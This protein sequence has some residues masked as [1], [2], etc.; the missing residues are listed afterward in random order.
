MAC[1]IK[2]SQE[3]I[4]L[5]VLTQ[6]GQPSLLFNAMASN[7]ILTK[8]QSLES[9]KNTFSSKFKAT[10]NSELI[11]QNGEPRLYYKSNTGQLFERYKEALDNTQTGD[12]K[13]GIINSDDVS[14]DPN[15][16]S[17]VVIT[18]GIQL[19]SEE[20]FT[21]MFTLNANSNPDTLEGFINNQIRLGYLN[22]KK[23]S[24]KLQGAGESLE[25]SIVNS[26]FVQ[27]S[28]NKQFGKENVT[29]YS[30]GT[31][32]II[33]TSQNTINY[34]GGEITKTKFIQDLKE[35][36]Q[37][38]LENK[39]GKA[40]V[41]GNAYDI[42]R[43]KN[44]LFKDGKKA[45]ET[46]NTFTEN[47]LSKSLKTFL[48]KLGVNITSIE[49]YSQRYADKNGVPVTA[50]ALADIA[51]KVVAFSEGE[52]GLTELTEET[53]HFA[54]EA[55]QDEET[56]QRMLENVH[57]TNEWK[58]DSQRYLE[59]YS[60]KYSGEQLDNIL[61]REVLGKV[62]A[63]K[64]TEQFQETQNTPVE[65]GFTNLLAD[66]WYSLIN[67][68]RSFITLSIRTELDNFTDTI[69]NNILNDQFDDIFDGSTLNKSQFVLYSLNDKRV[70][71]RLQSYYN[72]LQKINTQLK[73]SRVGNIDAPLNSV[74]GLLENTEEL[75][76][77]ESWIVVQQLNAGLYAPLNKTVRIVELAIKQFQ[78]GD[79]NQN[80]LYLD[81]ETIASIASLSD[82]KPALQDIITIVEND[83]LKEAPGVDKKSVL[84]DLKSKVEQINKLEGDERLLNSEGA[85][86]V[87]EAII[88]KSNLN[89][90]DAE[91]VRTKVTQETKDI[92]FFTK[93]FGQLRLANNVFLNLLGK[94]FSDNRTAANIETQQDIS[95]F[96]NYIEDNNFNLNKFR[97]IVE[98]DSSG[99]PTGRLISPVKLGEFYQDL[100]NKKVDLIRQSLN[101]D[102]TL[103]N[104]DVLKRIDQLN[105]EQ[106]GLYDKELSKWINENTERQ[107]QDSYYEQREL[108]TQWMSQ[109]TKA[110]I[111]SLSSRRYAITNKYAKGEIISDV[112]RIELEAIARERKFAKANTN[113]DGTTKNPDSIEGVISQDLIRADKEF[114][115][116][117]K[118]KVYTLQTEFVDNLKTLE[119]EQGNKKSLKW[120]YANGG[121][122][123]NSDFYD[124]LG[125]KNED[126]EK[127]KEPKVV[128][129]LRDVAGEE[130]INEDDA[131]KIEELA[132]TLEEALNE[133]SDILRKYQKAGNPSEVDASSMSEIAKD[134]IKELDI[135]IQKSFIEA[136]SKL[137]QNGITEIESPQVEIENTVNESYFA[138]LLDSGVKQSEIGTNV[139]GE[140]IYNNVSNDDRVAITKF[141][142]KVEDIQD[143]LTL[144][145]EPKDRR[146]FTTYFN[147]NSELSDDEFYDEVQDLLNSPE[148]KNT[149]KIQVAYGRTKLYSY[150]KRFAPKGYSEF[151][152]ALNNGQVTPSRLLTDRIALQEEFPVTQFIEITPSYIW[153]ENT[154]ENERNPNYN[155]N[156]EGGV[157]QPKLSRY[158]NSDYTERFSP[159]EEGQ[160]TKN[161][162]DFQMLQLFYAANRKINS[163][164]GVTTD[165][166]KL[167]QISKGRV[168]KIAEA[169]RVGVGETIKRSFKDT[170]LNRID[171]LDY[172]LTAENDSSHVIPM[173]YVY[174]LEETGDVSLSLGHTFAEMLH[175]SNLY[176]QK[177]KSLSSVMALLQQIEEQKF[178]NGKTGDNSNALAM[179]K[180]F[181]D[182]NVFGVTQSKKLEIDVFGYKVDVSRLALIVHRF[183]QYSS[184]AFSVPVSL[185]NFLTGSVNRNFIEARLGQFIQAD[186]NLYAEKEFDLK[187][188]PN[189]VRETGK[190]NRTSKT[191]KILEAAGVIDFRNRLQNSG[192]GRVAVAFNNLGYEGFLITDQIIKSKVFIATFDDIR[193][194]DGVGFMNYNQYKLRP[195]NNGLSK[196][197]INNK[198]KA[199][200]E[201]SLWN[202]LEN[203]GTEPLRIKQSVIDLYGEDT[204]NQVYNNALQKAAQT[205][206]IIDGQTTP[207]EKSLASRDYLLR[208]TTGMRSFLFLGLQSKFQGK[209]TLLQAGENVEGYYITGGRFVNNIVKKMISEKGITNLISA[210]KTEWGSLDDVGKTNMKRALA[211]Y[212]LYLTLIG[213]ATLLM[214]GADDDDSYLELLASYT[215]LRTTSET[216]GQ[217][218]TGVTSNVMDALDKP[219]IAMEFIKQ[220]SKGNFFDTVESGKYEGMNRL[221]SLVL[222]NTVAKQLYNMREL[223]ETRESYR[224]YNSETLYHL[225]SQKDTEEFLNYFRE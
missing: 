133:R 120:I 20:A 122:R 155:Q 125:V 18:E 129:R 53:A 80:K 215:L 202:S 181:V 118:D 193:A 44:S 144:N 124:A 78:N 176:K 131:I 134:R 187:E 111:K 218:P 162:E 48:G 12:I 191:Y 6:E 35:G 173:K 22:D 71:S 178:T 180:S 100:E 29:L 40:G 76:N 89:E 161:T 67:R 102:D 219:L 34:P 185:T 220:V 17:D 205:S 197:E 105:T 58:Q 62:L 208:F 109:D 87:V 14:Y 159:N 186:S 45:E 1:T 54:I 143:G 194:V 151:L 31:L 223:E 206:A 28:A 214:A 209:K 175:E 57:Q 77:A 30:D 16:H 119:S 141:A 4:I 90:A 15:S 203:E 123:F 69:A 153:N 169:T 32:D 192:L 21:E 225:S 25:V 164:Y 27:D 61:R 98:I 121:I 168:E 36:K 189:L 112:D 154:L 213:V 43:E 68:V 183:V 179:A 171:D 94:I 72:A 13:A 147:L 195:E 101:L 142:R 79:P 39:M 10:I 86:S 204:V 116:K 55:Y 146:F 88:A 41:V 95:S 211:E 148:Y 2:R 217:T 33:Y 47:Q 200:R 163:N 49:D 135:Q 201:N 37:P 212:A 85:N 3:G 84:R 106:R 96:I 64:L 97:T 188:A 56:L 114:A 73:K 222:K 140:F 113:E 160:A 130:D 38:S 196:S 132:Y 24:D 46:I 165:I 104:K 170:F 115:E 83:V 92:T 127:N 65:T 138:D 110:F 117:N 152:E 167:P 174:D 42:Y 136:N 9:Y 51:N 81:A 126:G 26:R 82:V 172:G 199:F 23:R 5:E 182:L 128:R 107:F 137:R 50:E 145:I 108:D 66:L 70:S 150:Y 198:W 166:Y 190:L 157:Y 156:W 99:N 91:L 8:E 103:K 52:I 177:K 74:K 149:A 224:F 139:E 158:Q 221:T 60:Q 63:R 59:V 11:D 210:V 93:L 207:E 184:L 75:N 7:P 216:A 19:N